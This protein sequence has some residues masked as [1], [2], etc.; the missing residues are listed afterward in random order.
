MGLK[1]QPEERMNKML[2][3]WGMFRNDIYIRFIKLSLYIEK[4]T[5]YIMKQMFLT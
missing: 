2:K 4:A 5:E 1:K 3:K